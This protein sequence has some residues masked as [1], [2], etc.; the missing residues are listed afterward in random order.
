MGYS[1]KYDK[2]KGE[3]YTFSEFQ[4]VE[5]KFEQMKFLAAI[6]KMQ[7]MKRDTLISFQRFHE[8]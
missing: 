6:F 7:I 5:E 1:R 2:G 3:I 4:G 8:F